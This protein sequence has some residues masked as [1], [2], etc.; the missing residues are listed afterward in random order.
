M[1]QQAL[2]IYDGDCAF[3]KQSLNWALTKLPQFSR[4]VAYQSINPSDYGLS[5]DQVKQK[6]W[7]V[8]GKQRL[9]GHRAVA[10]LFCNQDAF[11]WRMLG[12]LI[13]VGGPVSALSY[14]FIAANRHR[15]PGGTKECVINDRP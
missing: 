2:L 15:L 4:Y 10:W 12:W 13:R 9:S 7:L 14:F 6:V 3:C 11:G 1:N 5:T 8:D